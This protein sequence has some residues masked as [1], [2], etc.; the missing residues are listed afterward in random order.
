MGLV[1]IAAKEKFR[2]DLNRIHVTEEYTE[3]TDGHCL[4]RVKKDEMDPTDYPLA[5]IPGHEFKDDIDIQIPIDSIKNLKNP[6]E[7]RLPIL[8]FACVSTND[9]EVYVS[10][11]NLQT[12]NSV[13]IPE[14]IQEGKYPDT[15]QVIP[16]FKS[17]AIKFGLDARLIGKVFDYANK[18][19]NKRFVGMTFTIPKDY[20]GVSAIQIEFKTWS[21]QEVL[22]IVMPCRI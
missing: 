13:T 11:T 5:G 16:K 20:D 8:K 6:A 21:G 2:Y 1:N 4:M 12:V 7:S 17:D 10:T 14:T 15:N 22:A 19:G 9:K 18:H 3:A